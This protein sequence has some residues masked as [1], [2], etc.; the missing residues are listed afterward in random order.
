MEI[1]LLAAAA[2]VV[3]LVLGQPK[4]LSLPSAPLDPCAGY[5]FEQAALDASAAGAVQGAAAGPKGAG[6]GAALG[7]A[8]TVMQ[9]CGKDR[10]VRELAAARNRVC[11]KADKILRQLNAK[12]KGWDK[13]SCDQRCAYVAAAGPLL[14]QAVLA[15]NVAAS[16][17]KATANEIKRLDKNASELADDAGKAVS[18]GVDKVG[19][20]IKSGL[21]KAGVKL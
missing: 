3:A 8:G 16:A 14:M 4:G 7:L 1:A 13:W 11:A 6:A 17:A 18:S 15:G 10:F 21:S 2:A 19:D 20:T 12:P 9:G 5:N